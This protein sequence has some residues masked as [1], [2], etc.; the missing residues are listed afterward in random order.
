M[1]GL[2]AAVWQTAIK[3]LQDCCSTSVGLPPDSAEA[4]AAYKRANFCFQPLVHL[5]TP[6][7]KAV[8]KKV[9]LQQ[10]VGG[11]QCSITE[12]QSQ[13]Q[14]CLVLDLALDCVMTYSQ[15]SSKRQHQTSRTDKSHRHTFVNKQQPPVLSHEA[16]HLQLVLSSIGCCCCSSSTDNQ[17]LTRNSVVQHDFVNSVLV[18]RSPCSLVPHSLQQV[19]TVGILLLCG[20]PGS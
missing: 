1:S 19:S 15:A 16:I 8:W 13:E 2:A 10:K 6:L 11:P 17:V 18:F 20:Q 14:T 12:L 3:G 7:P 5:P 4:E 9:V